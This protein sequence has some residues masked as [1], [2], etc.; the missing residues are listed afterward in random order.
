MDPGKRNQL[1]TI[2]Q[3][4]AGV[5]GAGQPSGAWT[6]LAQEWAWA[7]GQG[8]VETIK[9]GAEQRAMQVSFRIRFRGTYSTGMRVTHAG[10]TYEIVA[11]RPDFERREFEDLVCQQLPG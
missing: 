11:L 2:L 7:V 1:I 8:G 4:A 6:S 9:A 5:D 10:I 3:Q